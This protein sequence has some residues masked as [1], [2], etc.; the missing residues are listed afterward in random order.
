[1]ETTKGN[2]EKSRMLAF[3]V[4]VEQWKLVNFRL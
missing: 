1:M 3:K 2:V 4:K